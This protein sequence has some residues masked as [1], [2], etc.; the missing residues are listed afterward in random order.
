MAS[1]IG[2][3]WA[4]AHWADDRIVAALLESGGY[5]AEALRE[6]GHVL[7]AA[8]TWLARMEG[9]TSRLGVWPALALAEAATT[10]A[11]VH[12][13]YGGIRDSL[14]QGGGAT[15]VRY[16]NSAGQSF[17]KSVEEIL[18]HVALHGQY[19][20]GKVN[21]LLRQAGESPGPVDYIA[22]IRGVPA[23]ITP[24]GR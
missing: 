17:E 21:L 2:K 8:E 19:H 5:P 13:G 23:A 4:H 12:A 11:M 6:D 24:P 14:A 10:T 15:P 1:E 22:F 16:V 20:R 18:M 9:R 3:L 7:G